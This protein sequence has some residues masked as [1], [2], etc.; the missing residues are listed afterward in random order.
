VDVQPDDLGANVG[1]VGRASGQEVSLV[2][3][4][5]LLLQIDVL[6][7]EQRKQA[8]EGG[9]ALELNHSVSLHF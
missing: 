8:E 6:D 7:P 1:T 5:L 4:D 3:E 9:V 2:G